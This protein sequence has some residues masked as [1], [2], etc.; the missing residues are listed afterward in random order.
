MAS[1]S[2]QTSV[3]LSI[4]AGAWDVQAVIQF[5]VNSGTL[6]GPI[7]GVSTNG[8]SFNLGFGSYVQGALNGGVFASPLVRVN[9]P[10]TVWALSFGVQ[11]S[12]STTVTPYL[13]ARQA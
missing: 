9:G 3:A 10:T 11:S 5:S 7:C 8:S 2:P 13:S 6:Q 12:G 1:G 4:P